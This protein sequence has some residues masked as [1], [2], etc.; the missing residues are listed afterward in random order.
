MSLN[1][2]G[3]GFLAEVI[4]CA[5]KIEAQNL[6]SKID[7]ITT[8]AENYKDEVSKYLE[9]V[10]INFTERQEHNKVLLEKALRLTNDVTT[11]KK[12]AEELTKKDM[13]KATV[14]LNQIKSQLE[15]FNVALSV[16]NQLIHIHEGCI[17]ASD[18]QDEEAYVESMKEIIAINDFIKT[19]PDD[20]RV[21][22][23]NE[24]ITNTQIIEN[25]LFKNMTDVFLKCV[26]KETDDDVTVLK[27]SKENDK[28]K[29]ILMAFSLHSSHIELLNEITKFLWDSVF[30]P[31][32][33]KEV[34]ILVFEDEMFNIL[35]INKEKD[36]KNKDYKLIFN[37]LK[38]VLQY[39]RTYFD[40]QLENDVST[41][42]YIGQDLRDNLSELIIKH[43]LENTIPSTADG[44]QEYRTVIAD[45]ESLQNELIA[46]KIF[47]EDTTSV[48]EYAN[49][50]DILFINKKC[51][52]YSNAAVTLMKKDLHESMEVG[53]VH[54][55]NN[56]L[57]EA[58]SDEFP[59][60]CV[61]KSCLEVLQLAEKLLQQ[62]ITNSDVNSGKLLCAVQNIFYKYG[63]VVYENHQKLL[64]TIPQQ[65][66]LYHNNC[67]YVAYTLVKWNKAYKGKSAFH[68]F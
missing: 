33:D 44:L 36:S 56:P 30:V 48:I 41:L 66:A 68:P 67:N 4:S 12:N 60:C 5:E 28:L 3:L 11:L 62:C 57:A 43:C 18:L 13:V 59:R 64:E 1:R 34:I 50:I 25:S 10:Y 26:I 63:S 15:E 38:T 21:E 19:I 9:N 22:A 46:S 53:V 51:Q 23:V 42:S 54:D 61:S 39:L 35:K 27:I 16:A 6:V 49:N 32:V 55:T 2:E 17:K 52:E 37:D 47:A 65:I 14:D 45:T 24:L 40:F 31:V 29:Q 20:E 8:E 7:E 58:A